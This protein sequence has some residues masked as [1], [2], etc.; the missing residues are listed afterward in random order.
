MIQ[1]DTVSSSSSSFRPKSAQLHPASRFG[2]GYVV[3]KGT[4]GNLAKPCEMFKALVPILATALLRL[5]RR[6]DFPEMVL[7]DLQ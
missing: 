7:A 6:L 4:V 1:S 2:L 5:G 3:I